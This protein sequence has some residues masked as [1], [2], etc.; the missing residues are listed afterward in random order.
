MPA[1]SLAQFKTMK[2]IATRSIAPKGSLTRKVAQEY[3]GH[4]SPKGLPAHAPKHKKMK[5]KW[6][7]NGR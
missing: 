1:R 6:L 3:V 5:G 4:Q 2:G 7:S